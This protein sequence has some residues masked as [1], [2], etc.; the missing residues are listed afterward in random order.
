MPTDCCLGLEESSLPAAPSETSIAS[1]AQL[2]R[3]T[4]LSELDPV[5]RIDGRNRTKADILV[6]RLGGVEIAVKDYS[7]R[8]G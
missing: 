7:R 5:R 8:S 3:A 4:E 2:I 1:L 6:Y